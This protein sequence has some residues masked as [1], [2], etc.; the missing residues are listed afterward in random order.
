MQ[1]SVVSVSVTR[2]AEYSAELVAD[3]AD[4]VGNSDMKDMDTLEFLS[5][6]TNVLMLQ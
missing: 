6:E 3:K 4:I 1:E 5:S 2:A